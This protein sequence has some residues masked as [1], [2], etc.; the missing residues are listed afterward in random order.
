[1]QEDAQAE[2]QRLRAEIEQ[3]KSQPGDEE[4]KSQCFK[5]SA[6]CYQFIRDHGGSHSGLRK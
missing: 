3:L 6:D 1:V 5:L 2:V 4:L